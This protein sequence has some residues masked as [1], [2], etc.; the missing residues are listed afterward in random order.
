MKGTKTYRI[1]QEDG[2]VD[3]IVGI[4]CPRQSAAKGERVK[5]QVERM[6]LLL[7]PYIGPSMRSIRNEDLEREGG[8]GE[9]EG[10]SGRDETHGGDKRGR[11]KERV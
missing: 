7:L 1:S 10:S 9:G 8:Q 4:P 11:M 5:N 2:K 6:L 3:G